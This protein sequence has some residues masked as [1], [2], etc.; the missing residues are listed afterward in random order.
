M[1]ALIRNLV[2]VLAG[3]LMLS[4]VLVIGDAT[5]ASAAPVVTSVSP[6]SGP[7]S[8]GTAITITGTGFTPGA[9]VRIG[10]G[11]GLVMP[12]AATNAVVVSPTEITATT[13]GPAI[14]GTFKVFVTQNGGNSNSG[15]GAVFTYTPVGAAPTVTNVSPKTGSV[16]GNTSLTITGTGFSNPSTVVVG[17][18]S[19]TTRAVRASNVDV[20]SSTEITATTAES[21]MAGTFSLYVSTSGG[22]SAASAG[23]NFTYAPTVTSVLANPGPS[24]GGTS[25]TIIGTGFQSPA[26]VLIGQGNG[27]VGAIAATNVNVISDTEIRATTGG[28]AT[29][30]TYS[31]FV[32]TQGIT[33]AANSA[34]H[35]TYT[36][37]VKSVNPKTGPTSGGTVIT[38]TGTGFSN[39]STV[40]IGQ[41]NGTI[42][43]IAATNVDVISNSEITAT[44]GGGATAGDFSVYVT[45]QGVISPG[46]FA[47]FTYTS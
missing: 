33:T 12:I 43:A 1:P 21:S 4:T 23:S 17:Q 28:G 40:L 24:S 7:A 37:T 29:A 9:R 14:A 16:G 32:T 22:T 35:F 27:T 18:G 44:T 8:G 13:G 5:V 15:A 41:G 25:M 20:V 19:G 38:I 6:N 26:T 36:P 42:G 45:T 11:D 47:H 46:S 30:G 31:V 34:A 3:V 39:P 10:Q 2:R